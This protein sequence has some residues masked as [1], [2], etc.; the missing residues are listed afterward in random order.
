MIGSASA[1]T[2]V[3]TAGECV[4]VVEHRPSGD[5]AYVPGLNRRGNKLASADVDGGAL[6]RMPHDIEIELDLTHRLG[7]PTGPKA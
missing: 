5:I 1:E 3:I 7:L 4:H 2:L 6:L